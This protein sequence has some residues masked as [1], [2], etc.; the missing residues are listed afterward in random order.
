MNQDS[1]GEQV[2]VAPRRYV[3]CICP[4]PTIDQIFK[5]PRLQGGG[6]SYGA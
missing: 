4:H 2:S 3:L 6:V 1:A 5:R